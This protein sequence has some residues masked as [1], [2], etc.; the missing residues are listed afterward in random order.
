MKIVI[1][2][3]EVICSQ[4]INIEKKILSPSSVILNNCYPKEWEND[5]DY[6]SRFYFPKDFSRCYIEDDDNS[7]LFDGVIKNSGN[8]SIRPTEPKYCTLQVIDYKLLLSEC[9]T[10]DFVIENTTVTEAI[11][12]VIN[13]IS[14]YG[15]DVGV[16]AIDNDT[17]IRA[18]S[19]VD[20]TPYD[21]LQYF[22]EITNSIWFTRHDNERIKIDYYSYDNLP[23]KEDIRYDTEYFNEKEIIDM[24]YSYNTYDYRNRQTILSGLVYS[25]DEY[26]EELT[27]DGFSTIYTLEQTVGTIISVKVEN[28]EKTVGTLSDKKLG[29]YCDFYY[30][31]GTNELEANTSYISGT[32]IYVVYLPMVQGRE[33]VS[34]EAEIQRIQ[35]QIHKTGVIS[36]YETR[37]DVT[38]SDELK[39]IAE[40][41][42][43]YK[44]KAEILLTVVS[45]QNIYEIGDTVFFNIN[46]SE[47]SNL[48]QKYLVKAK[49]IQITHFG[50]SSQ[51]E[52]ITYTYTLSSSFNSES[53]I[54]YFDNQRRKADSNIKEGEFVTRYIDNNVTGN[55]IFNE[56]TFTEISIEYDNVLDFMLDAPLVK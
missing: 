53:A 12:E 3:K 45:K 39:L 29:I 51:D 50:T 16:I 47:L 23:Q 31:S 15:F 21:M 6:V 25:D 17:I 55:I 5:K 13:S 1:S 49:K 18:Y 32:S 56:P 2:D 42:L 40:T 43:K 20:K 14:S 4:D 7:I 8:I 54:N 36:R 27:S 26:A 41:Y 22:A 28:T 48:R 24:Y 52:F 10:L 38:S 11:S 44:G 30:E 33:V 34:N 9:G 19:T 35:N 46:E 37:N